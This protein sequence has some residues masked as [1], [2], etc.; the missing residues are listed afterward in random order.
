[1]ESQRAGSVALRVMERM[2][3]EGFATG[4]EAIVD[5]LCSPDLIE[6]QF[7]LSGTGATAIAKV[8]RGISDVHAAMPDVRF[9]IEDWSESG[10]TI[11]I[12]AEAKGTN[13]GP[14]F[15]PPT[16]QAVRLTVIDVARI[17]D[18]RIVEHW[19]VP[20]RFAL[21]VQLGRLAVPVS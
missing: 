11:W 4:N 13:K 18:G 14:F 8:K 12:R 5:D 7:G 9:T 19:G 3:N 17:Q 20:D 16:G 2:L 10:D 1:M 21:L 15:G 6:H